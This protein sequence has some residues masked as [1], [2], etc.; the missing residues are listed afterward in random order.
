MHEHAIAGKIILPDAEDKSIIETVCLNCVFAEWEPID[1][2]GEWG[3]QCGCAFNIIP[4]MRDQGAD[5]KYNADEEKKL[6]YCSIVDRVCVYC[7]PHRGWASRFPDGVNLKE[8]ARNEVKPVMGFILIVN[9]LEDLQPMLKSITEMTFKPSDVHV[10]FRTAGAVRPVAALQMLKDYLCP[11]S[12]TYRIDYILEENATDLRIADIAYKKI[13]RS[14]FATFADG[15][16]IPSDFIDTIDK[17]LND[18]LERFL[19]LKPIDGINGM[20]AQTRITKQ[21]GGNNEDAVFNKLERVAEDQQCQYLVRPVSDII[22]SMK[23]QQ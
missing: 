13:K 15:F 4:R 14:Y 2:G 11:H 9:N 5:V 22:P 20:V 21:I 1:E 7:R 8:I 16:K 6:H 10:Q 17:A 12:I 23:S 19:L 18:R 3:E